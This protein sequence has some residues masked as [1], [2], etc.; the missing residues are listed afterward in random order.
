MNDYD[1]G[2]L[3]IPRSPGPEWDARRIDKLIHQTFMGR[4]APVSRGVG[5]QESPLLWRALRANAEKV[6]NYLTSER[7]HSAYRSYY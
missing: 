2:S 5:I 4:S 6:V 3:H 1:V 7:V